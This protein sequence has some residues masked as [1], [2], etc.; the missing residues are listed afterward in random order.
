MRSKS[1]SIKITPSGGVFF[2]GDSPRARA[3]PY[4]TSSE[5]R[6]LHAIFEPFGSWL[7]C[8]CLWEGTEHP[9]RTGIREGACVRMARYN[10]PLALI[11][12]IGKYLDGLAGG[13]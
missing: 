5:W 4:L 10:P 11:H 1:R 2:C 12:S 13:S 7:G 3:V 9:V 6:E 8:G